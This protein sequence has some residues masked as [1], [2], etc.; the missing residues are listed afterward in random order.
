[1]KSSEVNFWQSK[2]TLL[3]TALKISLERISSDHKIEKILSTLCA[4]SSPICAQKAALFLVKDELLQFTAGYNFQ[5]C[6]NCS[7]SHINAY[8]YGIAAHKT[9]TTFFPQKRAIHL[10]KEATTWD[11]PHYCVC[12]TDGQTN[13]GMLIIFCTEPQDDH[14]TINFIEDIAHILEI[15]LSAIKAEEKTTREMKEIASAVAHEVRNPLAGIRGMAQ[16]IEEEVSP[17]SDAHECTTRI[18]RQVDRLNTLLCD[19]FDYVRPQKTEISQVD[20]EAIVSDTRALVEKKLSHTKIQFHFEMQKNIP[21]ITADPNQLQQVLLNLFLNSIDAIQQNGKI[22]LIIKKVTADKRRL[23]TRQF[24]DLK[25]D[26][27][28]ILFRFIDSG[29]GISE[30][31]MLHI[32]DP[33]FTTKKEGTGLGLA[34]VHRIVKENRASIFTKSSPESGTVFYIFFKRT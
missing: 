23:Y 27:G 4:P 19:F 15:I 7:P 14:E 21:T 13:L 2:Y 11:A 16:S 20:I 1:M 25:V 26:I 32:F 31:N 8:H 34:T 6:D 28:D 30:K 29:P 17:T 18:I 3:N 10:L 33:F 22:S 12:L 5:E 9:Q 24:K